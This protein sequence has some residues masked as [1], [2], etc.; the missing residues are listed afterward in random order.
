MD[1][2]G[3]LIERA[4]STAECIQFHAFDDCNSM[5]SRSGRLVRIETEFRRLTPYWMGRVVWWEVEACV[6]EAGTTKW[7]LRLGW[8]GTERKLGTV[9]MMLPLGEKDQAE[10]VSFV[11]WVTATPLLITFKSPKLHCACLLV[12]QFD[13]C[14][15]PDYMAS[16]ER[17]RN[18]GKCK[19]AIRG[20]TLLLPHSLYPIV[21][22][23]DKDVRSSWHKVPHFGV[24]LHLRPLQKKT[25]GLYRHIK[26]QNT[27]A[28]N[29]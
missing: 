11:K 28:L 10:K 6:V 16:S 19:W 29:Y 23:A 25:L 24:R 2:I 3:Q 22:S 12:T 20:L 13:R 9:T 14:I 17:G 7:T 21:I 15:H 26:Y 27:P 4:S 1:R 18:N 5:L 8:G